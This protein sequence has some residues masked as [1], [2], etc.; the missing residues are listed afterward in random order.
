MRIAIAAVGAI[1]IAIGN[2]A[3]SMLTVNHS[4]GVGLETIAAR[5]VM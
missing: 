5:P 2:D 1:E 3:Q 4:I